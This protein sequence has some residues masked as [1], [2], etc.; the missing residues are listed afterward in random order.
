MRMKA[1]PKAPDLRAAKKAAAMWMS[2]TVAMREEV[3]VKD[4]RLANQVRLH[5]PKHAYAEIIYNL[6]ITRTYL[7]FCYVR[8]VCKI[9]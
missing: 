5:L 8:K 6:N 2:R 9:L 3:N 4:P 1:D 7:Y